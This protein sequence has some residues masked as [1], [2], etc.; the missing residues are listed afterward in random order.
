MKKI[1]S[2][3]I[4]A[5]GTLFAQ[6]GNPGE[7]SKSFALPNFYIE[8]L[9]N[10]GAKPGLSRLDVYIQVP[11]SSVQFVRNDSL[12]TASYTV[13]LTIFDENKENIFYDQNWVEH[14]R[15]NSFEEANSPYS[16]N[17]SQRSIELK[18]GK[19][20]LFCSVED[21]DSKK[22]SI[23]EAVLN[24]RAFSD[25]LGISDVLLIDKI[26]KDKDGDQ[27]VPDVA[28]IITNDTETLP[29]HYEI[30]SPDDAKYTIAYT[31]KDSRDT[32]LYKNSEEKNLV[33]GVNLITYTLSNFKMALG[34]LHLGI[35]VLKDGKELKS[36]IKYLSGRIAGLP[37]SISSVDDAI[38]EMA[39]IASGATIKYI[40][41][42]AT[43]EE[44]LKKFFDF[45]DTK[46]PLP[47]SENNPVMKE[48]YKRVD[49][50]NRHFKG[51]PSGWKSDM[52]MVYIVLGPPDLVERQP[53]P[54]ESNPYEVWTY[55]HLNRQF[56]FYDATGFGTYRLQN[57]D[58]DILNG[59][60]LR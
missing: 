54:A 16:S 30:Y 1:L 52:G 31:L 32:L 13:T 3:L 38:D 15:T 47:N 56:V 57:P 58:Y 36:Y 46:K 4:L 28:R 23:N 53:M 55:S 20:S 45:W 41:N 50:A 40:K 14:L 22:L 24:V 27:L 42:S 33:K 59:A 19:Y 39:Y 48:Y 26:I 7:D 6:I 25:S 35:T 49:Y 34:E 21:G 9:S 11:F 8:A 29:L 43:N 37:A 51:T 44:K 17:Y 12:F 60:G 2:I 10:K 5:A 18:P